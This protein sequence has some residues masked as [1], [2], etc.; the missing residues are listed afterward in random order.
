MRQNLNFDKLRISGKEEHGEHK[1]QDAFTRGRHLMI[2]GRPS[3][4]RTRSVL[5]VTAD[6]NNTR[7]A[8][9]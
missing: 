6:N 5:E 1:D 3:P 8:V 4:E 9:Y 7:Q 2:P